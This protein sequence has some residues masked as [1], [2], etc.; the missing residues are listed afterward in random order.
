MTALETLQNLNARYRE[1]VETL[2]ANAKPFAGWFG[3]GSGSPKDSPLHGRFYEDVN[4]LAAQLAEGKPSAEEAAGFIA[5]LLRA[6]KEAGQDSLAYWTCMAAH[7]AALPLIPFL[8]PEDAAA[9]AGT[10]AVDVPRRE[11]MPLQKKVLDALLA[12]GEEG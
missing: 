4:A 7:G 11:R 3:L 6:Q 9:L 8:R 12:R 2:L 1:D 10:Y 5:Y